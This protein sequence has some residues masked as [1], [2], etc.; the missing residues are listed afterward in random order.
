M[1]QLDRAWDSLVTLTLQSGVLCLLAGAGLLLLRKASAAGRHLLLALLVGT[2][3]TVPVLS[4]L[5]PHWRVGLPSPGPEPQQPFALHAAAPVRSPGGPTEPRVGLP[6]RELSALAPSAAGPTPA[7]SS[8]DLVSAEP[9]RLPLPTNSVSLGEARRVQ[10]P[11]R[12]MSLCKETVV[13][14][15]LLGCVVALLRLTAGLISAGR[16]TS[17]E[18]TTD[19][20]LILM[21]TQAKSEL[22]IGRSIAVRQLRPGSTLPV[23][24]TWGALR[25]TLLLPTTFLE[26]PQDRRRMVLLHELAHIQ[27][28]DWLVQMLAQIVRAFYW[29][30]PLVWWTTHRLQEESE[31]AC[32]DTVLLTGAAPA[33]YAETLLEVLRTMNRP[34]TPASSPNSILCMARPPI[35]TRLHAILSPQLR[36]RP[37][38]PMTLL[39]SATAAVCAVSLATMQVAAGPAPAAHSFSARRP[40]P[41]VTLRVYGAR[42]PG[43]TPA[44]LRLASRQ[45]G[46]EKQQAKPRQLH[47]EQEAAAL[48]QK[49]DALEQRLAQNQQENAVL[50]QRLRALEAQ[51]E[52]SAAMNSTLGLQSEKQ[53]A[54]AAKL[55]DVPNVAQIAAL[56]AVLRG[57]QHQQAL[58]QTQMKQAE[59][60]YR[61]GITTYQEARKHNAELESMRLRIDA[62][63]GQIT[64]M[65]AGHK[66]FSGEQNLN[67]LRLRLGELRAK[68]RAEQEN[69]I[70]KKAHYNA[71]IVSG[72]DLNSAELNVV[73]A[74]AAIDEA[75]A[76]ISRNRSSSAAHGSSKTGL[77]K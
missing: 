38:R 20:A 75:L 1:I 51:H 33:A 45:S 72:S 54:E 69:L 23:P 44:R 55:G 37:S 36:Q 11:L 14:T 46:V 19:T 5:M 57:M 21:V 2:L 24:L 3:L 58:V 26:W 52:A 64:D 42:L 48:R 12:L 68:L 7:L 62:M 61:N 74:Q 17:R 6:H 16:I 10:I 67:D 47:D 65:K 9:R 77:G 25:P 4:F 30:H 56:E 70:F 29:F 50:R 35:E 39:A 66:M 63:T 43:Q 34:K 32:D 76:E 28:A 13:A 73:R 71:G 40:G 53:A 41:A 49:L 18:T 60:L 59:E 27:R 22:R 31:R 15:W 8:Q